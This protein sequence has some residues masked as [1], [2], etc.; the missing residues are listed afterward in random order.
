MTC[1][2]TPEI[3]VIMSVYNGEECLAQAI[4]SILCQTFKD[5][6]FIIINDGSTDNS[7]N[8][9]NTYCDDRIRLIANDVNVGLPRSLNKAISAARGKYIARFDAD[10]IS[11]KD[12][13]SVQYE[14]MEN[15]RE[16]GVCGS[17]IKLFDCSANGAVCRYS[18]DPD[19][20]KCQLFFMN[21]LCH[22]SVI[23]RRDLI[24]K[25]ALLYDEDFELAQD[26]E[27][28][29]RAIHVTKLGNIDKVLLMYRQHSGKPTLARHL[30][31][32]SFGHKVRFNQL[33]SLGITLTAAERETYMDIF[34]ENTS[35]DKYDICDVIDLF[36]KI[37]KAILATGG[38]EARCVKE[39]IA[40]M[41]F[42]FV[43]NKPV[44]NPAAYVR[45]VR[46]PIGKMMTMS[47]KVKIM[48]RYLRAVL[49][50]QR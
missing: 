15:N 44:G 13:L 6:E 34:S 5:Y 10:D 8:I 3:S 25:Y 28:W 18:S 50:K 43:V 49:K 11:L 9:I 27:L 4:E 41:F 35:L 19:L 38:Y 7:I 32:L 1:S 33:D 29:T 37:S 48:A 30:R 26:Y 24:D 20:L 16:I 31:Q 46:S 36:L 22:S 21:P 17:W 40:Q 39:T 12:R 42:S 14:F 47:L 45:I 2:N 23:F